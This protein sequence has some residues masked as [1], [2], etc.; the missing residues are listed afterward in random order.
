MAEIIPFPNASL[1]HP[2]SPA[3]L[4]DNLAYSEDAALHQMIQAREYILQVSR[5]LETMNAELQ[6]LA[7]RS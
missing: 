2:A 1:T 7:K 3:E 5:K 6:L 4:E